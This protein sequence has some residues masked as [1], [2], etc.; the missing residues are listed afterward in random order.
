MKKIIVT[1]LFSF[2]VFSPIA[3]AGSFKKGGVC[4]AG[5]DKKFNCSCIEEEGL[6]IDQIYAKGFK[7]VAVHPESTRVSTTIYIEQQ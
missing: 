1:T 7:I 5:N 2:F 3:L 4:W 6:S